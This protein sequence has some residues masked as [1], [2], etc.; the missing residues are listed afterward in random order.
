MVTDRLAVRFP[1]GSV[2]TYGP[3]SGDRAEIEITSPGTVRRLCLFPERTLGEAFTDGTIVLRN[4]PLRALLVL[5]SRNMRAGTQPLWIQAMNRA[6]PTVRR[7]THHNTTGKSRAN[8]AHHYDLSDQLYRLF[9]DRDMQYSCAYF[10]DPDMTLE[11]A[12]AAKKAHIARKLNLTPDC[13]VLDIGCGWGGMA[14]TL[15]RDYGVRVTG[16]TLS[17]NQLATAQ[18]RAEEAGL[19]HR[20]TFAL[21]DYRHVT[22]TFDRIVSVGM[23]EHVGRNQLP[24]FFGKVHDL[25][26]E[27]GLAL[28]H[29]ISNQG[30]RTVESDWIRRYIFPGYSIPPLSVLQRSIETTDLFVCDVEPLRIHYAKT[31][32]HWFERFWAHK[33]EL[34]PQFDARFAR[35]WQYYL[36]SMSVGFREGKLLVYQIQLGKNLAAA[37]LTRDYMYPRA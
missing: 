26:A 28:I 32:D 14:L 17:E 36:T 16:I 20:V 5:L 30:H 13:H 3:D 27:D 22:E 9:L 8:V 33:H 34:P 21:K 4:T 10:S 15:A 2:E 23:L 35:M 12:Q 18:R 24:T 29:T 7:I 6:T 25:L 1:D 31:L 37:P 19:T 11:E